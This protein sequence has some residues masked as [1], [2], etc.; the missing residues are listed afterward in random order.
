[1]VSK[2]F[3]RFLRNSQT[4]QSIVIL[5]LGMVGLLA[6]VGIAVDIS[7]LFVRFNTLRRAVDSASIAAA[8]Q[9]RQD[10]TMG[11]VGLAARQFIEFHNLNPRDVRVETCHTAQGID[12]DPNTPGDQIDETLCTA[13]Q[14]KLVRV[15]AEIE[16]PTVFLRLLGFD[17]I[18]LTA[19]ATS[20]TA[21]LDVVLIM[22]V[23]ESMLN[24]TRYEDWAT[25]G[26][27]YAYVPPRAYSLNEFSG[28][29]TTGGGDPNSIFGRGLADGTYD[30]TDVNTALDA[31]YDDFWQ[32]D[33]LGVPQ[34]E[35]N[36]RLMYSLG[37]NL[38]TANDNYPVQVFAPNGAEF[39]VG[40]SFNAQPRE[41]CRVR[42]HPYSQGIPV[43]QYIRDLYSANSITFQGNN[44]GNFQPTYNF[45]G[46]CN[47]PGNMI[48][49]GTIGADGNLANPGTIIPDPLVAP[50]V[51]ANNDFSDLICEPFKSA[52]DAT[53]LFLERIDFVRGDRVGFVTFDRTGFV[54]D[55]DGDQ[56][57]QNH[58]IEDFGTALDTLNRM[59]G[60]RADPNF[61]DWDE[62]NG[63]WIGFAQ[64]YV[65]GNSIP[66]DYGSVDPT[67]ISYNN[68]PV[69]DDCPFQN[70]AMTYPYSRF[71][72]RGYTGT[73][74]NGEFID[75]SA[76]LYNVMTP[77]ITVAPWSAAA[78]LRNLTILN[79]YELWASCRGTNIGAALREGNNA[80]V[81]PTTS[82]TEG[83]VWVMIML[84]DGAAGASDPARRHGVV[85]QPP[86]PYADALGSGF[87]PVQKFGLRGQYGSFGVCPY[88][89][90]LPDGSV[91]AAELTDT[92]GEDPIIFPFCLDER[93]ETRHF[94][95]PDI[96]RATNGGDS[97]VGGPTNY[98]VGFGPGAR[99]RNYVYTDS[100]ELNAANG[101]VYDI[102]V[103]DYPTDAA[104]G[105]TC[106]L[107]YD[108]DDYAR[109]WAD[110]VGRVWDTTS[111]TVTLPTI[112]TIGFG[113]RFP[114][115][116]S[117]GTPGTCA[118][119]VPDCLGEELLRYIADVGDNFQIDTNY[120]QDYLDDG[121]L[122]GSLTA[123]EYGAP[124]ICE[125]P[126]T[127]P[128]D[129]GGYDPSTQSVEFLPP[130]ES[131]GNY[132]NAPDE[133]EL[134]VVFDEIASRMFTRLA[135]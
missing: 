98:E 55:P 78:S 33:L 110:F 127:I 31:F 38:P 105:V 116:S 53:R 15:T 81:D 115:G 36:N 1:M 12:I 93:P 56:T 25:I 77:D 125:P 118:D 41:A 120:Q 90:V 66:I 60:V 86:Q 95:Y 117:P 107:Y 24:E 106:D 8:G 47:D 35:V 82:R 48:Q 46:C 64:G 100:L 85:A 59:I 108:V 6:I 89:Q 50:S 57:V 104:I 132:F 17:S 102:D 49:D 103:G 10:R 72:T 128:G 3:K 37:S 112:F 42:F 109:D 61:Y 43:P 123:T 91:A 54:I 88:G 114:E 76:A 18:T 92:A 96:E 119:N 121:M 52:R 5:A 26:Q 45:Y 73:L 133:E 68:Y 80:L 21:V 69:K 83:T 7:I 70:A 22:D 130:T 40:T 2:R 84:T 51:A 13:D 135:G 99:D 87:G 79:S 9:M 32:R 39:P 71:A 74:P 29:T 34:A 62:A 27:G 134:Q 122:N 131:C 30:G 94:C 11:E 28:D 126:S 4:G 101:H 113:L 16:S 75:G 19:S 63:G 129:L 44:W 14:R 23:S 124:G 111:D 20:E 97:S 65:N 58:M 67:A